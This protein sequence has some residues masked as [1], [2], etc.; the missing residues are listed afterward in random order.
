MKSVLEYLEQSAVKYNDKIAVE[1]EDKKCS[2]KELELLS[3]K[4]GSFL[5]DYIKPRKPVAVFMDKGVDALVSFMG[6]VY[7]GGFHCMINVKHPLSRIEQI[8]HVLNTDVILTTAKYKDL[9][10]DVSFEG[11]IV[12]IEDVESVPVNN[13]RLQEIRN[14]SMDIDPLYGI[15]TSGSTGIPKCVLVSHRSVI[16]FIDNFTKIFDINADD[17]VGNQAPFDFDVSVKDIYSCLK[18]GAKLL[19]IP[20]SYFTL[21]TKVL[22][23]ICDRKATTL[24]WAVSA[25]CLLST[26]RG[27][28]Y[29][30]PYDVRKILFSGEMM[31]MNQLKTWMEYLPDTKFV[32]LYGP[33]EITCNCTY[34]EIGS[35]IFEKNVIPIGKPFPNRKVLLLDKEDRQVVSPGVSGEICVS[36]I[37]VAIG[38]YNNPVNTKEHFIQNP[39]NHD[40]REIIYRTGD[41][42]FYDDEGN[43][44]FAGRKDFQIKHMGH[45]IELEEI[46]NMLQR[47]R[48][49]ER[50]CC[51][52]DNEKNRIVAF[53]MGAEDKKIIRESLAKKLPNYMLPNAWYRVNE[54]PITKNGKID[55]AK[56]LS[57]Y[58]LSKKKNVV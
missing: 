51:I 23:Y 50:S 9:L 27:L 6:I 21:P 47:I 10:D 5:S 11:K 53:Y 46:D 56:L 24:I 57:D 39:V 19:V 54:M 26:L 58:K 49:V 34:Y 43:I 12:C 52:F 40:Y 31:P 16:D 35:D 3:K 45:R 2:F 41:M 4:T 14:Q 38:Y 15:F 25:L 48:Q 13:D 44:V 36:G 20:T 42:G 55:R 32:N 17:I 28:Q 33:T 30:V 29:K 1:E 7:A 18:T 37:S 8:L 22:D